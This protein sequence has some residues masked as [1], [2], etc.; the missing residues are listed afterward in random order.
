MELAKK[1]LLGFKDELLGS[2]KAIIKDEVGV[3]VTTLRQEIR[4]GDRNTQE[5]LMQEIKASEYRVKAELRQE[6]RQANQETIESVADLLDSNLLP[7]LDNHERR[8]TRLETRR[9]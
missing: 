1:Q 9:A 7:Q 3:V 5:L 8:L 6:I 4:D 2:I